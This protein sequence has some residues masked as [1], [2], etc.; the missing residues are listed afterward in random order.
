MLTV[1]HIAFLVSEK[2]GTFFQNHLVN[3]RDK[4][5]E[6]ERVTDKPKEEQLTPT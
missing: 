2:L 1:T 6:G 5:K 3:V 4:E